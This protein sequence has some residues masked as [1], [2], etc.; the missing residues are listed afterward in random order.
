[1]WCRSGD[2]LVRVDS[3]MNVV[4]I[5]P[6]TLLPKL[7]AHTKADTFTTLVNFFSEDKSPV[8]KI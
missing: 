7:K 4:A 1:M 8:G 6:E 2:E 5:T 3:S